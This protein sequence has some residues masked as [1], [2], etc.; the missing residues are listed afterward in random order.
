MK[1]QIQQFGSLFLKKNLPEFGPGDTVRISLRVSEGEKERI[2]VFEGVVIQ[3]KGKALSKTVTVRKVSGNVAT[4]R[5]FPVH[6][7]AV[8]EIKRTRK[9]KTRRSR[10]FYLRELRGKAARIKEDRAGLA[11]A[12]LI[13]EQKKQEPVEQKPKDEK[14]KQDAKPAQKE[15]PKKAEPKAEKKPA[16]KE[17]KKEEKPAEA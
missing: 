9:G 10:L 3:V 5:V 1:P 15:A 2:Q 11:K 14:P 6:S 4:E 17:E 7:P 13:K 8:A 16:K 12:I